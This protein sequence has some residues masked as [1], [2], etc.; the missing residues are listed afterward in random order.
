M[1]APKAPEPEWVELFNLD[2]AS[3]DLTGWKIAVKSKSATLGQFILGPTAFVVIT[4]DTSLFRKRHPQSTAVVLQAAVPTLS[5]SGDDIELRSASEVTIDSLRYSPKWGGSNG[6]SVERKEADSSSTDSLNWGSS[7]A[8]DSSTP[9]L[10]NSIT[11]AD[12][13]LGIDSLRADFNRDTL[14]LHFRIAN[15]GR[16]VAS[17]PK[18]EIYRDD[19]HNGIFEPS[20]LILHTTFS[21]IRSLTGF[22]TEIYLP[23]QPI[24][25]FRLEAKI[26]ESGDMNS[27]NDTA[28]IGILAGLSPGKVVINEVMYAPKSPEPEWI[29]LLNT[30][31][32]TV[33]LRGDTIRTNSSSVSLTEF[34]M[35]PGSFLVVTSQDSLLRLSRPL[36]TSSIAI[37]PAALPTLS[38]SGGTLQLRDARGTLIDSF[39]FSPTFGGIATTTHS[40]S[41]ERFAPE[42][43]ANDTSTVKSSVDSAG[44]TPGAPNSIR[45]LDDDLAILRTSAT[46]SQ[47]SNATVSVTLYNTGRKR[48][49]SVSINVVSLDPPSTVPLYTL[50]RQVSIAP[51]DSFVVS[52]DLSLPR[53][54]KNT[55]NISADHL[56]DQRPSNDTSALTLFYPIPAHG[57]PINEVMFAPLTSSSQWIEFY[58]ATTLPI[59]T[60]SLLLRITKNPTSQYFH[61]PSRTF[62]PRSYFVLAADSA[63]FNSFPQLSQNPNVLFV[64][65]S[66][67]GLSG[68][69]CGIS[70]L[71]PD[72]TFID[73]VYSN[74]QWNLIS[75]SSGTSIER[76]SLDQSGLDSTNWQPSIALL[77]GTPAAKNSV[78]FAS[79]SSSSMDLKI[80]PNPFTPD[81]DGIGDVASLAFTTGS[82]SEASVTAR[83]QDMEGRVVRTLALDLRTYLSGTL[84]FDGKRDDGRL[85][86]IGLYIISI[87]AKDDLGI[88]RSTRAGVSIAKRT[89]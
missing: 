37:F 77:G 19:N 53:Y 59:E 51:A 62:S 44:A 61:V 82:T 87:D 75:S 18:F 30:S 65:R 63:L 76:I 60:G 7:I 46:V 24:D 67:L 27:A 69:N 64:G 35:A 10:K 70:V 56:G 41:L 32:D 79:S 17:D 28:T 14:Q 74:A 72:S 40:L 1:Y 80:T 23:A 26:V 86:P 21:P 36:Q 6:Y 83:V 85:L 49:D 58:N 11:P 25:S 48:I 34:R 12:L 42:L 5:N 54:G 68:S 4:K 13:D 84:A 29:E 88:T 47:S 16:L 15:K 43:P 89:R 45:R 81:G 9:G 52:M 2:S 66:S 55:L 50:T 78:S 57:L 39:V 33:E 8:R 22:D 20:E 71:N 31:T 73:S 3:V 38:N